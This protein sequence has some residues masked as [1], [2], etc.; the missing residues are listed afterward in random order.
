MEVKLKAVILAAG[1]GTRIGNQIP[2]CLMTLPSGDT[3]LG[4]QIHILKNIGIKEII[5]VVGFKKNI[6]MEQYPDVIYKYNPF[7]HVTNT[8]KSLMMAMESVSED[9]LIWINGDV[10]LEPEVVK[11]VLSS[12]GNII[13]VNKS[14]CGDE[15]VK[16]TTDESGKIIRIS[17]TISGAEGESVGVNKITASHFGLFSDSLR[18]CGDNDYFE[19]GIEICI[20]KGTEFFP[21]DISDCDCIEVDFKEDFERVKEISK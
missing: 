11:R 6:I 21:V 4:N 2:K 20:D 5:V 7:Y 17:K 18:E 16:Y 10:F 1:S 14:K 3:I 12:K 9:D 8:S 15:E 19:K 13:A